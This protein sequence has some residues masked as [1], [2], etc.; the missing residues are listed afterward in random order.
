MKGHQLDDGFGG[1]RQH[2]AVLVFGG[3]G[4]PGAEQHREYRHRQRDDQRDIAD[5]RNRGEG[6][7]LAQDGFERRRHRLELQRDVGN[8]ADDRDHRDGGGDR[9]AL[10]VARGDEIGDR[11]DV[12]RFRQLDHAAQQRRAERDHQD[13]AD[14]D[15]E[16]VDAGAGGEADRAEERPG[17]AVDRQRQ[18]IDQRAGAA[19]L[20]RREAVAVAGD[21]KQEPDVAESGCDHAPVVQHGCLPPSAFRR[22]YR[23]RR[24]S[25]YKRIGPAAHGATGPNSCFARRVTRPPAIS[26]C[27]GRPR[28]S[29]TCS[30]A[31][32]S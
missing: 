2:Q 31:S 26:C 7:V 14:I 28:R 6:L 32:A 23:G 20:G 9:L 19:A 11:G 29:Q 24:G 18:R 10:A 4:L 5:D 1:D 30:S 8:R 17:G 15:R 21:Q 13:R 27:S 12:L 3:V 22:R 16:K 25:Q